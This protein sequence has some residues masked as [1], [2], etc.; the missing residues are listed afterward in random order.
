M[1]ANLVLFL[2]HHQVSLRPL[3]RHF[4]DGTC[5][6]RALVVLRSLS[7]HGSNMLCKQ[8]VCGL[9]RFSK[10]TICTAAPSSNSRRAPSQA[11]ALCSTADVKRSPQHW[12]HASPHM[13]SPGRVQNI[14]TLPIT[15]QSVHPTWSHT[16]CSHMGSF[17]DFGTGR[18]NLLGQYPA[19]F[20]YQV[21]SLNYVSCCKIENPI[22]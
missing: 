11:L 2:L 3:E 5:F 22:P 9:G 13:V 12:S 10:P 7:E 16:S 18:A 21:S 19:S 4:Q 8:A 20:Y 17:D 14:P 1:I 15:M 6:S